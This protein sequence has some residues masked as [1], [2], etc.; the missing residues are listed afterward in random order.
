M[1]RKPFSYLLILLL[2]LQFLPYNSNA[3]ENMPFSDEMRAEENEEILKAY[4]FSE[5]IAG[6]I[7]VFAD[8]YGIEEIDTLDDDVLVDL[9][10]EEMETEDNKD[11]VLI[12]YTK[13]DEELGEEELII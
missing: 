8:P 6:N 12:R 13:D 1:L 3:E 10:E 7:S 5:G 9:L 2:V 11:F 4:I